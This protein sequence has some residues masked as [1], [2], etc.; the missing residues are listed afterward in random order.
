MAVVL[1]GISY[2]LTGWMGVVVLFVSTA[3]GMMAA[4]FNTR[5]SYCLGGLILPVLIS[6][7]GHTGAVMSLLGLG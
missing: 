7:T 3:I 5:R 4:A 1:V 2:A 6:M